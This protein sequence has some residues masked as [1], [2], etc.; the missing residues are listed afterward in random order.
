[1]QV[2]IDIPDDLAKQLEPEREHLAEILRLGL[3][4]R[5]SNANTLW[6]EIVS[7]VGRGPKPAEIVQFQASEAAQERFARAP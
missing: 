3:C 2:I 6:R 4:R 1:M 7:F 5:W